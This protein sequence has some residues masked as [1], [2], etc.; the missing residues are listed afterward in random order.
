MKYR[1]PKTKKTRPRYLYGLRIPTNI[2]NPIARITNPQKSSL[3][4]KFN[5]FIFAPPYST[6]FII[7]YEP[8]GWIVPSGF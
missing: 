7:N 6:K 3:F 2:K 1:I 4:L 8:K 5:S